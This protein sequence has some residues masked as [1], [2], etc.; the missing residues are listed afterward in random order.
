MH[1]F[2]FSRFG[3]IYHVQHKQQLKLFPQRMLTKL[4][5][6]LQR[7]DV[8]KGVRPAISATVVWLG[9]KESGRVQK[10][11]KKVAIVLQGKMKFW[12]QMAGCHHRQNKWLERICWS[13]Q[14]VYF[15]I[16]VTASRSI[17]LFY[18]KI[19]DFRNPVLGAGL[20][21]Y[22]F[23][24]C[25]LS[26]SA[27][28]SVQWSIFRREKKKN[29]VNHI[30]HLCGEVFSLFSLWNKIL[31]RIFFHSNKYLKRSY[32]YSRERRKEIEKVFIQI[33][34]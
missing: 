6:E 25:H 16:L 23:Q 12:F 32:K 26:S 30:S 13:V 31:L 28:L 27:F 1:G 14:D 10:G 7:K 33:Y 11:E 19:I 4:F 15:N 29:I 17:Y 18:T 9:L 5:C 21:S 22:I 8:K 3:D 34:L 20:E 24:F 2:F